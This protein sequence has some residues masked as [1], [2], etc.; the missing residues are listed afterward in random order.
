MKKVVCGILAMVCVLTLC[1]CGT[2]SSNVPIETLESAFKTIDSKLSFDVT[3]NGTGYNFNY[4]DDNFLYEISYNGIANKD[5]MVTSI[6]IVIDN[7]DIDILTNESKLLD[8]IGK[9]SKELLLKE[10]PGNYCFIEA[11][12][13]YNQLCV[14]E[15]EPKLSDAEILA[16]VV[17]IFATEKI[18]EKNGWTIKA[19]TDGSNKTCTITATFVG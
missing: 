12:E 19:T 6:D 16:E 8:S 2:A 10:I 4:E 18:I 11:L 15:N 1:G 14:T 13:L 3:E 17:V 7:V 9:S 5:Q